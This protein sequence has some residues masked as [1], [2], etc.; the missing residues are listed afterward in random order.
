M[1]RYYFDQYGSPRVSTTKELTLLS[2]YL[3]Q[4]IQSNQ[5]AIETLLDECLKKENDASITEWTGNAH[6][7]NISPYEISIH[8][9]YDD[10]YGELKID[11]KLFIQSLINWRAL[12]VDHKETEQK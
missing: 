4:D 7:I 5:S 8:N 6:T 2:S 10:S 3:E 11:R 12:V 9:E 1:I